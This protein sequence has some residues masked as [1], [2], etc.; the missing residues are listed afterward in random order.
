ME[1]VSVEFMILVLVV[2][3]LIGVYTLVRM[4][5]VIW[6]D[7]FGPK[8]KPNAHEEAH[9]SQVGFVQ[10]PWPSPNRREDV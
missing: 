6:K 1:A 2:V 4:G 8:D 7:L 9:P 10:D 5:M 3:L